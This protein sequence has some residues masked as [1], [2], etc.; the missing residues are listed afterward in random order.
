MN[1]AILIIPQT[2]I[3]ILEMLLPHNQPYLMPNRRLKIFKI[4]MLIDCIMVDIFFIIMNQ[5]PKICILI[6]G[7]NFFLSTVALEI[8][9]AIEKKHCKKDR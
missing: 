5:F 6:F 4:V 9:I 1:G 3:L 8:L 7:V 2:C